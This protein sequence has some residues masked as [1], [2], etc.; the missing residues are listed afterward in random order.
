MF[1][2]DNM[3]FTIVTA[4]TPDYEQ[5]LLLTLPTWKR[6][7]QFENQPMIIFCNGFTD[8]QTRFNNLWPNLKV[9]DWDLPL[10]ESKRETMLSAFVI[11]SEKYVDTEYWCKLDCDSFFTNS[12]D[13]FEENDFGYDLCT[14]GWKYSFTKDLIKIKEWVN[15]KNIPGKCPLDNMILDPNTKLTGH[16]RIISWCCMHKTDFVKEVISYIGNEKMPCPSHDTL[17]WYFA[18]RLPNRK[19]HRKRLKHLGSNTKTRIN[20][21]RSMLEQL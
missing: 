19:W 14:S 11:G 4:V 21:I 16:K 2:R 3:N 13:L 6:K 5:K 7:P 8:Y 17:L 1:G 15:N 12:V 18:E 20:S 10:S 9:I